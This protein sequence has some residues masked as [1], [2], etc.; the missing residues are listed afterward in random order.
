MRYLDA[1]ALVKRYVRESGSSVVDSLFVGATPIA[2]SRV[3]H[4][5][6][7]SALARRCRE[8]DLSERRYSVAARQF[9]TEWN[10]LVRVDVTEDLLVDARRLLERH[11]LRGFDA[12][13][14]ASAISLRKELDIEVTLAA[15]DRRQLDAAVAEGLEVVDVSAA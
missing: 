3:A 14:V 2:T 4:T 1:S 8:G 5:E 11:P 9:D 13:H 6:V 7:F 10:A 15:A 12:I